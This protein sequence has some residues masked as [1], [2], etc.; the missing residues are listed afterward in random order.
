[1]GVCWLIQISAPSSSPWASNTINFT[2]P[3]FWLSLALNISMTLAIVCR[4]FLFRW[5]IS[6][7]LGPGYGQ[8]YTSIAAMLIESAF[9]YS[10][11][12]LAFLIPFALNNAIQNTFVQMVGEVQV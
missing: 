10:S 11:F 4:L 1:M 12:S 6:R 5:R 3:Y 7:T 2:A 8:Q 9:L